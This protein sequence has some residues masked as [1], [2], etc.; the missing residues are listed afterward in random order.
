MNDNDSPQ[1]FDRFRVTVM[2]AVEDNPKARKRA[3]EQAA[4]HQAFSRLM[5]LFKAQNKFGS[6]GLL[7]IWL[8][9]VLTGFRGRIHIALM[10]IVRR[11][12]VE[13]P[14]LRDVVA[15]W[16]MVK[17]PRPPAE[18]TAR[19]MEW[20]TWLHNEGYPSEPQR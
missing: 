10:N 15:L 5:T 8:A 11:D 20:D 1:P 6:L 17:V 16:L 14:T 3:R 18:L 2:A 9:I 13:D 7:L 19:L 4:K 12:D